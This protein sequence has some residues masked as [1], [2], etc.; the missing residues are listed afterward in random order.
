MR[1]LTLPSW[2][3]STA[4]EIWYVKFHQHPPM[5]NLLFIIELTLSSANWPTCWWVLCLVLLQVPK[6]FVLLQIFCATPKMYLHIV[7]VTNHTGSNFIL[8]VVARAISNFSK[9]Y[10]FLIS[11]IWKMSRIF[12]SSLAIKDN[13]KVAYLEKNQV[14]QIYIW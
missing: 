11:R 5:A 13:L 1:N 9:N 2:F 8:M 4:L 6:Y 3:Y 10:T 12:F 14:I 7:A